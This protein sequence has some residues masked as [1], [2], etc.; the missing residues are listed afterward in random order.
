MWQNLRASPLK[1]MGLSAGMRLGPYE[2]VGLIKAFFKTP[3]R[4]F[5]GRAFRRG[6]RRAR[7]RGGVETRLANP[8]GSRHEGEIRAS[9]TEPALLL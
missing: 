2:I 3:E 1:G 4:G 5:V 8:E 6:P 7:L 9:G